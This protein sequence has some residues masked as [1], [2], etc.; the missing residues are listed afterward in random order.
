MNLAVR[1]ENTNITY[2]IPVIRIKYIRKENYF[3]FFTLDTM[4]NAIS[5][6][7][8]EEELIRGLENLVLLQ[9]YSFG[10]D[11]FFSPEY[12]KSLMGG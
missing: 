6:I 3:I 7:H 10:T 11:S 5:T 12:V 9:M 8:A 1:I 4:G 2:I